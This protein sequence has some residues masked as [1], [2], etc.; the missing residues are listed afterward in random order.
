MSLEQLHTK[1]A[2]LSKLLLDVNAP[3]A[4]YNV[5]NTERVHVSNVIFV[6]MGTVLADIARLRARPL[7][8]PKPRA[9][10][11]AV[12]AVDGDATP[13]SVTVVLV[14]DDTACRSARKR[15]HPETDDRAAKVPCLDAGAAR[16]P[17]Q[18]E[19]S[20]CPRP[21]DV[22]N[23]PP[24]SFVHVQA[25]ANELGLSGQPRRPEAYRPQ[26]GFWLGMANSLG[27]TPPPGVVGV[28]E[29]P[30]RWGAPA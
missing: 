27:M 17:P 15:P 22:N 20:S 26:G 21:P 12:D 10:V 24:G 19:P 30:G 28:P 2:D 4:I 5:S 9:T 6:N 1:L 14:D 18:D 7:P 13:T 29:D 25:R 16:E 11:A 3:E 23:R 8:A